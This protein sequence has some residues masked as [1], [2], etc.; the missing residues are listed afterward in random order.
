MIY[1]PTEDIKIVIDGQENQQSI[2]DRRHF[3]GAKYGYSQSVGH[4]ACQAH[5]RLKNVFKEPWKRLVDVNSCFRRFFT[6][7]YI[8]QS[9]VSTVAIH[10]DYHQVNIYRYMVC[11]YISSDLN[12]FVLPKS[13]TC[14]KWNLYNN[15][16]TYKHPSFYI[17]FFSYLIFTL[18]YIP[19]FLI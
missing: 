10:V 1:L 3:F 11:S 2:E 6:C 4:D 16:L 14:N 12:R 19:Y 15:E 17:N 7:N 8:A 13:S 9:R 18:Y 5:S